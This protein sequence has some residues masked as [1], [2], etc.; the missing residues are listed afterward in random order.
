MNQFSSIG[1]SSNGKSQMTTS[2]PSRWQIAALKYDGRP[3]YTWPATYLDDD[4]DHLRLSTLIGGILIHTTRGFDEVQELA[5]D[6]TFWRGRWYNVFT[7]YDED[8][9]LRNFY[10]NVAM[11]LEI[12]Q[13]LS[14]STLK[15]VDLDLDVRVF[16]DGRHELLD[17]DE[18]IDHTAKFGYPLAVQERA[19]RAVEEILALVAARSGPFSAIM[20]G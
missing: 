2:L 11:P 9:R 19:R 15:Y 12:D 10:C 13:S 18:F 17:E 8:H 7:N 1:N 5:S 20:G 6:L 16:P 3:H 14:I 4:G